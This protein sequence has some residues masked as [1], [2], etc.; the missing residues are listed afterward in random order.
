MRTIDKKTWVR[1]IHFDRFVNMHYAHFNLCANIEITAFYRY[2]KQEGISINIAII[3]LLARTANDIPEFRQ[4]IRG[5]EVVEHEV[6]HPS[7]TIMVEDD[8]FSFCEF[9]YVENFSAF[10][11]HAAARIKAIKENLSLDDPPGRDDL[12]F[13]TAIPWVS[14]TSFMHP[15][16]E[17]P[18]G[19]IPMMAWGKFF[20]EGEVMKMPLSVQGHH[21]LVDGLHVGRY[22]EKVQAYLDEPEVLFGEE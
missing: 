14:F 21:A 10:K 5:D 18:A 16:F 2:V 19:S 15:I 9:N 20:K 11:T 7:S 13:F 8:L 6:V 22:Y 4:R 3:Y 17:I 12:L 1:G